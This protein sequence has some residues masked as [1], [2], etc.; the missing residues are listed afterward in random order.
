MKRQLTKWEKIFANKVTNK[1]LTSK[2][3]KQNMQFIIKKPNN[4]IKKWTD[5]LNRHFS[6][7]DTQMAKRY[8]K[9]CST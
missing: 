8:M 2:I 6:K 4:P 3:Q 5:D 7:E 9:R 1:E